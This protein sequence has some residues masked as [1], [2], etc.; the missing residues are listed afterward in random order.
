MKKSFDGKFSLEELKNT[1]ITEEQLGFCTL[2]DLAKRDEP[3]AANVGD[4]QDSQNAAPPKPLVLIEIKPEDNE[5]TII[6]QKKQEGFV[7][8][9]SNQVYVSGKINK[10][11]VLR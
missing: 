6:N 10:I 4:F 8:I 11:A 1:L 3:P 2:T 7:L 5:Q 9:S